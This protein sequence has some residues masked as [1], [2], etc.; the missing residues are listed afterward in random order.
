MTDEEKQKNKPKKIPKN[1]ADKLENRELERL[2]KELKFFMNN[3]Q[4]KGKRQ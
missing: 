3:F 1:Q 2:L 4:K